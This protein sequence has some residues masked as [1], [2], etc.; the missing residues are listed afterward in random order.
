MIYSALEKATAARHLDILGGFHPNDQDTSVAGLGTIIMLGQ[1]EPGFWQYFTQEQEI[2]DGMPDPLDRWSERVIT[3]LAASLGAQPFFPFSGPPYQP[4][5]QWAL[6]SGRCHASPINLLVHDTAG[7][8]VSFRGA[9]GFSEVLELPPTTASPCETCVS[10]PCTNACP[11]DA[12]SQGVYDVPACVAEI[13]MLETHDCQTLGCGARRACPVSQ[14]YGRVAA[15]SAYHM[16][17]F[18]KNAPKTNPRASR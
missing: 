9:L 13:S 8:F 15:Q 1:S 16:Q 6:R 10:Q 11:V 5:Y 3:G 17:V 7:L 18:L 2:R 12:F 14:N 4:F